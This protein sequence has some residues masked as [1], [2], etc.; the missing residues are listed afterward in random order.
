MRVGGVHLSAGRLGKLGQAVVRQGRELEVAEDVE[1]RGRGL[2]LRDAKPREDLGTVRRVAVHAGPAGATLV[3]LGLAGSP[4]L[5]SDDVGTR[6]F[7]VALRVSD[8]PEVGSVGVV[9]APLAVAE[10]GVQLFL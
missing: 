4:G 2:A 9:L 5:G 6:Q 1:T 8:S 7:H 10:G 3:P